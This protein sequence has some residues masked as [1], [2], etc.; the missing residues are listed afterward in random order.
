MADI[1]EQ[2]QAV[3]NGVVRDARLQFQAQARAVPRDR[4]PAEFRE[5][6]S[7]APAAALKTASP[8]FV[9]IFFGPK[10]AGEPLRRPGL[11]TS[12]VRETNVDDFL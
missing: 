1:D 11:R 7:K 5:E 9:G 10:L 2:N 12:P 3:V 6:L 8:E 4:N